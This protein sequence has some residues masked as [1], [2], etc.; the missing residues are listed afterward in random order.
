MHTRWLFILLV[1]ALTLPAHATTRYALPGGSGGSTCSNGTNPSTPLNGF[2]N[3]VQCTGA[4]DTLI[5]QN[6]TY[7]GNYRNWNGTIN[8]PRGTDWSGGKV[9]IKSQ[10]PYGAHLVGSIDMH[11]VNS[12]NGIAPQFIEFDGLDLDGG[13]TGDTTSS[14]GESV[15][16]LQ[17]PEIR[18]INSKIHDVNQQVIQGGEGPLYLINNEIYNG[19]VY[20]D[21]NLWTSAA[22]VARCGNPG[23]CACTNGAYCYYGHPQNSLFEGNTWHNCK[24]MA[25]HLYWGSPPSGTQ[26]LTGNTIR[27]NILYNNSTDD[28]ERH[29]SLSTM[30]LTVGGNNLVYNNIFYDNCLGYGNCEGI[31]TN[32]N[33]GDFLYNN[34]LTGNNSNGIYLYPGSSNAI[35]RNNIVYNNAQTAILFT[36]GSGHIFCP[37]SQPNCNVTANPSFVSPAEHNYQLQSGSVARGVGVNL[38]STFTTDIGGNTRPS[39]G[40]WDSGAW[41]YGATPLVL[42]A[43]T[44]LRLLSLVP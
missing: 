26:P 3:G 1:L 15:L 28:G 23:G 22:C 35:V 36:G 12:G 27:N 32:K 8:Y 41:Q 4:G 6:G 25:M 20:Y 42:P 21:T 34:T 38:T 17:A 7:T 33:T 16:S 30:I 24:G 5:L 40:N 43:P 2:I 44:N 31:L 18:V 9:I 37:G 10:N 13:A 14:F 29:T 11:A 39:S 19:W